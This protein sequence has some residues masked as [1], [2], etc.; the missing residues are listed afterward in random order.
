MR[1]GLAIGLTALSLGAGCSSDDTV[2]APTTTEPPPAYVGQVGAPVHARATN[3]ATA[4]ITLNSLSW[5]PAPCA[6]GWGCA[7]AELTIMN[8]SALPFKYTEDYVTSS[9]GGGSQPWTQPE[10]STSVGVGGSPQVNYVEIN[11]V[12]P[13]RRG[14]VDPRRT[15]H[16]FVGFALDGGSNLDRGTALFIKVS[17]PDSVEN[18]EAGWQTHV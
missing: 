11:K 6:G 10:D 18:T 5:V 12:P 17:D 2:S 3:G 9:Y 7:V 1:L 4:D 16:G 15:V 13:L 14:A 8:T